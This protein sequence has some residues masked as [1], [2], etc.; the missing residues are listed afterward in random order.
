MSRETSGGFVVWFTGLS[1]S[2]KSTL[3]S[4]L[5][6]ELRD[7][8]VHVELLDGDEV[9]AHL[10][11]GLGFS[12][13]DRDTNVGRVGF[14]ARL[15]AR[16][17]AG[18][19]TAAISPYRAAREEVRQRTD[20]FLEVWCRAPIAELA[21]RD[22]KG[23]YDKALRGEIT[24]FTGVDDPYEEPFAADVVCETSEEPVE[25][26][27]ARV[28]A[29]LVERGWVHG[30]SAPTAAPPHDLDAVAHGGSIEE[31]L[32][33]ASAHAELLARARGL[34]TL[35][36]GV[37]IEDTLD[38]L[39]TGLLSPLRGFTT[40]REDRAI[41]DER[42][43]ERGIAWTTR[44]LLSAPEDHP[45]AAA[46]KS[47]MIALRGLE[48][49]PRAILE[50]TE[51]FQIAPK[52]REIAGEVT[53]LRTRDKLP[54]VSEVRTAL[55]DAGHR[56]V[57]GFIQRRAQ[58]DGAVVRAA[59]LVADAVIVA[60]SGAT[61][62]I[63]ALD[64]PPL[65]ER[66]VFA[67]RIARLPSRAVDDAVLEVIALKNLG[68]S[69]AIIDPVPLASTGELCVGLGAGPIGASSLVRAHLARWSRSELGIDV[70]VLDS[71]EHDARVAIE[72]ASPLPLPPALLDEVVVAYRAGR[73]AYH[74]LSHVA[75]VTCTLESV[76]ERLGTPR[77][78]ESFLAAVFH[79]AVYEAG[80]EGNEAKSAQLARAAIGRHLTHAKVDVERV[81]HLIEL[82]AR[83]GSHAPEDVDLAAS[84]FL[85]A[86]MAI[87]G[88]PASVFDLY[89]QSIAYEYAAAVPRDVY[90]AGRT[91][92]LDKLLAAPRIFLS[93]D[94]RDRL[95]DAARQNLKRALERLPTV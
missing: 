33:P 24:N 41:V 29:A 67:V 52:V 74:D 43:L 85:D 63:S 71:S 66:R 94:F 60:W 32:A 81:V 16:S 27:L 36:V 17:G 4:K 46:A 68:A 45:C 93:E 3:A 83:H 23:L 54:L 7:R 82:T 8:A 11:K 78:L 21:K 14:V 77:S 9:R 39:A 1:G 58:V 92:F 70:V 51:T 12:R 15:L 40:E 34:P 53:V 59:L 75:E 38:A 20:R 89:D 6:A 19:I 5:A 22:P 90:L 80:A 73:R 57:A 28:V 50:V 35:A 55:R 84:L 44:V 42:R 25:A 37:Q 86:D 76:E 49:D 65:D 31:R 91:R 10:S 62:D 47:T 88:A 30:G 2:G 79:D 26:S 87:L 95:E 13:E 18:V 64:L 72:E 56:R 61:P 69:I 48:A